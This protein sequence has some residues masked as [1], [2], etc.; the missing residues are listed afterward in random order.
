MIELASEKLENMNLS[1]SFN[2][3][4]PKFL[5]CMSHLYGPQVT[6]NIEELM[7]SSKPVTISL[8]NFKPKLLKNFNI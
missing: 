5:Q 3:S 1:S 2:T 4:A 8:H 6:N 7:P